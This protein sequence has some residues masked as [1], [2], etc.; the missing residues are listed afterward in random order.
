MQRFQ[1]RIGTDFDP[2]TLDGYAR[3]WREKRH[4]TA[5]PNETHFDSQSALSVG[6]WAQRLLETVEIQAVLIEQLNERLKAV[7]A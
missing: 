5:M 7:E 2:L 1:R 3:H 4:L 6:G